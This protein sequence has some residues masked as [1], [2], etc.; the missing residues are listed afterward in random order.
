MWNSSLA[1]HWVPDKGWNLDEF[2]RHENRM[3]FPALSVSENL[4]L[5]SKSDLLAC[6][7]DVCA[8][9]SDVPETTCIIHNGAAIIQMLKPAAAKHFVEYLRDVFIPYITTKLQ[10]AAR[11][12]L[13]WDRYSTDSLKASTHA[14][15]GQGMRRRVLTDVTMPWYW[16]NFLRVDSNKTE[17]FTFLSDAL[18]TLFS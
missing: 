2:F 13:V 6:L 16:Q 10:T 17:M 4:R 5:G 1:V 3:C 11:L 8:A 7:E 18:L 9:R 12:D 14:K 15:R